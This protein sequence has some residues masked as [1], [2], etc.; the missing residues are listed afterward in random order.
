MLALSVR[1][2]EALI[3]GNISYGG[4]GR[5]STCIATSWQI[6]FVKDFRLV[7]LKTECVSCCMRC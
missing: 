1:L 6:P 2:P 7:S 4:R 5:S 3:E